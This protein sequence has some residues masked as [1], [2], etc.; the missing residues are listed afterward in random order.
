MTFTHPNKQ[1][2]NRKVRTDHVQLYTELDSN[3]RKIIRA[4]L[5]RFQEDGVTFSGTSRTLAGA[6]RS[7]ANELD[8]NHKFAGA[9]AQ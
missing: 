4:T 1:L 8:S 2:R 7:L 9:N 3:R 6:L 5:G